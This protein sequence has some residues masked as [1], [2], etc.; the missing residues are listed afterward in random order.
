MIDHS[1]C[2]FMVDNEALYDLCRRA[3]DIERPTCIHEPEPTSLGTFVTESVPEVDS[4]VTKK[5]EKRYSEIQEV[6]ARLHPLAFWI[7]VRRLFLHFLSRHDGQEDGVQLPQRRLSRSPIS[8]PRFSAS[9]STL[10]RTRR[11]IVFGSN[12]SGCIRRSGSRI[13]ATKA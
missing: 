1:D 10:S 4:H 6:L 2:A 8:S 12:M 7:R 11:S 9:F 13:R 3:L 5:L